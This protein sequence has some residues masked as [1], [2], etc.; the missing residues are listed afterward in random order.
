MSKCVDCTVHDLSYTHGLSLPTSTPT[1]RPCSDF[2]ECVR[3]RG[4]G[5]GNEDERKFC[6]VISEALRWKSHILHV[7]LILDFFLIVILFSA[8]HLVNSK[9]VYSWGCSKCTV[10]NVTRE[11]G[12]V[13]YT[14]ILLQPAERTEMVC[15]QTRGCQFHANPKLCN[16]C[17]FKVALINTIQQLTDQICT[18]QYSITI[19]TLLSPCSILAFFAS[20]F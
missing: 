14:Q 13:D 5:E 1:S 19:I 3:A 10:H 11:T 16:S 8:S 15:L 20:C 2:K 12:S 7:N 9:R 6:K 17:N 18:L 4:W